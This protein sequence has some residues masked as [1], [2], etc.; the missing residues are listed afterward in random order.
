MRILHVI[1][2][3]DRGGAENHLQTLIEGQRAAGHSVGVAYLKGSAEWREHYDALGVRV[4]DLG[5]RQYGDLVPLLRLRSLVVGADVIHAHLPPAELYARLALLGRSRAIA[6]VISKHNDNPFYRGPFAGALARWVA[7]RAHTVIAISDA[8]NAYMAEAG[9]PAAK[10]RTIHYGLRLS[11]EPPAAAVAALRNEWG[12]PDLLFVT[13]ARLVEQK[14]LHVLI[15]AYRQYRAVSTA[16]SRLCIVG[17]GP[18]RE[19]LMAQAQASGL[20]SHV[21]WAGRRADIPVVMRA[22]DVFVLSSIHEGFGLVLL[23][24][25]EAGKPV[26]ATRVSAI[27]EVVM[28]GATGALVTP[29]DAAALAA[30][31]AAMED[32]QLR[33]R[34]GAAGRARLVQRFPEG[35]MIEQTLAAYP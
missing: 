17:D 5:M 31:L 16:N 28:D 1:T 23:E 22:L 19:P 26:V 13:V 18:L 8:V 34:L 25:M 9:L 35:R 3:I 10:L 6:F 32:Q 4:H 27:P 12:A 7:R 2:T 14:A 33:G 11:P 20:A 21:T 15:E 29:N 24:A 30:A